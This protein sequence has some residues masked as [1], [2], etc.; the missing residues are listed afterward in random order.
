[1]R[2]RITHEYTT[3]S[4]AEVV[5]CL[6]WKRSSTRCGATNREL[7]QLMLDYAFRHV[8]AV[9]F[10]IGPENWRSRR[11]VEKIGG[12][13]VREEVVTRNDR[14]ERRVVYRIVRW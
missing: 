1:M 10:H 5:V 14:E 3:T 4:L 11:A 8:E 2:N 6:W 7:K 13:F 12:A 9:Q